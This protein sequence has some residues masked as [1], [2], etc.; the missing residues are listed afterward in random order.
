MPW[1]MG[2]I[3]V[4]ACY[5]GIY[6]QKNGVV[7]VLDQLKPLI[8]DF[9]QKYVAS[10][11]AALPPEAVTT[12]PTKDQLLNEVVDLKDKIGR[13]DRTSAL[14]PRPSDAIAL[15]IENSDV[16][17]FTLLIWNSKI[18]ITRRGLF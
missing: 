5:V 10:W 4:E 16:D 14:M 17:A 11:F 13:V 15:K 3:M 9:D 1:L 2:M 6:A 7:A 18:E 12:S 8:Q